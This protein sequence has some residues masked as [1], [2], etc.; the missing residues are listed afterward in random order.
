MFV[1]SVQVNNLSYKTKQN[2]TTHLQV[3]T[4]LTWQNIILSLNEGLVG[5][6]YAIDMEGNVSSCIVTSNVFTHK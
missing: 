5:D 4:K 3:S 2:N 6:M 1:K